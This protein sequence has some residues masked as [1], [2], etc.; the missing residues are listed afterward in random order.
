MTDVPLRSFCGRK[1]GARARE[2]PPCEKTTGSWYDTVFAHDFLVAC[3]GA[4]VS[5]T[6]WC[7]KESTTKAGLC[8]PSVLD[9]D[10]T[11]LQTTE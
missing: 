9:V 3:T 5:G 1:Q 11:M 7:K 6:L 8:P 10:T 2:M 4:P